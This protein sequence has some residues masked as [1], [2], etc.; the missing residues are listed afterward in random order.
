M[1]FDLAFG[2]SNGNSTDR[3]HSINYTEVDKCFKL[4]ANTVHRGPN[5]N[6]IKQHEIINL[7]A[8]YEKK[9][10]CAVSINVTTCDCLCTN[11]NNKL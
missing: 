6:H 11:N 2:M 4:C 7:F 5:F 3:G 1:I 8:T 9:K 10:M